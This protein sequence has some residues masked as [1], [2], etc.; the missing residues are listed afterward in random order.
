MF[1][2]ARLGAGMRIATAFA[3]GAEFDSVTFTVTTV[4]GQDTSSGGFLTG[5]SGVGVIQGFPESGMSS[6]VEWQQNL[7]NFAVIA[8][9]PSG[10]GGSDGCPSDTQ[11]V[12]AWCVDT[13]EASVWSDAAGTGSRFGDSSDNYPCDD[14]G[15]GCGGIFAVSRNGVL[16]SRL[17]TWFQAQQACLNAG[18][19]LLPNAIWQGAAADT[20]DSDDCTVNS[21]DP[22]ATGNKDDCVSDWGTFDMVGN[23]GEWVADWMQPNSAAG[24]SNS[25]AQYG[26]DSITG[27]NDA[28]PTSRRFPAALIR[29]GDYNDGTDAGVFALEA[30]RGPA[31]DSSTVGFRCGRKK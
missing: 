7:Q 29:G 24:G 16:P 2:L 30:R 3:A 14:N 27:V 28:T 12:G 19:Q 13:Y 31:Y 26:E 25:T 22:V 4:A 1:N 17:I 9:G 15:N 8:S 21:S 5:A 6:T 11:E 10:G 18:K 20:P 23:V